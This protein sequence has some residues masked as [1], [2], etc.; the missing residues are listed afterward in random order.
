MILIYIKLINK[1]T[2]IKIMYLT[3]IFDENLE[4]IY[5]NICFSY[6]FYVNWILII[7]KLSI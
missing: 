5:I 6:K 7:Y 1:P 3:Y 2:I 4:L